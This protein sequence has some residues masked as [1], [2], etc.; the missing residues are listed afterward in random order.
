MPPCLCTRQVIPGKTILRLHKKV[1]PGI[2]TTHL[3]IGTT[4]S[5]FCYHTED[6]GL[7]S[8]NF[9]WHGAPKVW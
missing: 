5:R 4:A 8:V 9:L 1:V 3:Y 6:G 7:V 2:N